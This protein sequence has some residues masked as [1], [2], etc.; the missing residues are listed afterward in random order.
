MRLVVGFL[1]FLV[2]LVFL[3]V[4]LS[5]GRGRAC[6]LSQPAAAGGQGFARRVFFVQAAQ[7]GGTIGGSSEPTMAIEG[8]RTVRMCSRGGE[9]YNI[10]LA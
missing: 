7:V 1:V 3:M 2:F 10:A 4:F 9:W 5:P 8:L 6:W